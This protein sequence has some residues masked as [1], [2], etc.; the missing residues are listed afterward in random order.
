M[1]MNSRPSPATDP[2]EQ[3]QMYVAHCKALFEEK[4][5]DV[6]RPGSVSLRL[7]CSGESMET[8]VSFVQFDGS[9]YFQ[10]VTEDIEDIMGAA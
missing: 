10:R 7:T 1:K 9:L 3:G 4:F 8:V 6:A 2:L 5:K